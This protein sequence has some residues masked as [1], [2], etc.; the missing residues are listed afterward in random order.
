MYVW[1]WLQIDNFGGFRRF[2]RRPP[3]SATGFVHK[4][5]HPSG[6]KNSFLGEGVQTFSDFLKCGGGEGEEGKFR[7]IIFQLF[8]IFGPL[9]GEEVNLF[10]DYLGEG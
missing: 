3:G 8:S 6:I 1:C 4:Q 2:T 5:T 7:N 9:P 10:Q